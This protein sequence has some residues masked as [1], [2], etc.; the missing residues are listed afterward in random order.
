MS[1]TSQRPSV[2]D[3]LQ[4]R[5]E[6]MA[7]GGESLA[8]H[9]GQIVFIDKGLP[10]E[11]IE[12]EVL[13]AKKDFLR[14]R[15]T[16]VLEAS[17]E[18]REPPC[19][20]VAKGCGGCDWQHLS[21]EAQ[22]KYKISLL[23]EGLNRIPL[24]AEALERGASFESV[25]S[26]QVWNY[27]NRMQFHRSNQGRPALRGRSSH[28]D[29]EIS[30]CLIA[31]EALNQFLRQKTHKKTLPQR[32]EVGVTSVSPGWVLAPTNYGGAG[33]G[34]S[35]VNRGINSLLKERLIQEVERIHPRHFLEL[36]AGS[37]NFTFAL[38]SAFEDLTAVALEEFRPSVNAAQYLASSLEMNSRVEF[39]CSPSERVQSFIEPE[40]DFLLAD[41]PRQGLSEEVTNALLYHSFHT[42]FYVSCDPATLLRDLR[43]LLGS[44]QLKSVILYNMFPQTHHFETFVVL[45]RQDKGKRS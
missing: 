21:D 37:G 24:A 18:R 45:T 41:P 1:G 22:L 7:L 31:E 32:F 13:Q 19:P 20:N 17:R 29:V 30:E 11:W 12:C 9:E 26:P 14:C 5:V 6:K 3:R 4:L 27:R 28:I 16:Q 8:R 33:L 39:V 42:I 38:L 43:K 36:Y 25:E 2:G 34:F 35:Q 44:Y 10:G 23:R 15:V 40:P